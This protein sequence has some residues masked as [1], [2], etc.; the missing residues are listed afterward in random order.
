MECATKSAMD[1]VKPILG[2]FS[3]I[4]GAPIAFIL[5]VWLLVC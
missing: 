3:V 2:E 1:L 4:R 5:S